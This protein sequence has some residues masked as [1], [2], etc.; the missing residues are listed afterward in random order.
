MFWPG[1]GEALSRTIEAEAAISD[2][3]AEAF[4]RWAPD[5]RAAVLPTLTG[6][7]VN[8]D[9]ALVA[10]ALPPDPDALA[11]TQS[12]WQQHAD[13]VIL[14]GLA[15]IWAAAVY[16]TVSDLGGGIIDT[17]E[18]VVDTAVL[19]I[20]L[21][22]LVGMRREEV[23]DAVGYVDA[24]PELA[25]A[26]DDY[27]ATKRDGVYAAPSLVHAKVEAALSNMTTTV[28]R[29]AVDAATPDAP[30]PT[31]TVEVIPET[32]PEVLRARAA[33]VLE[34]SSP[35]MRD[36]AR[37]EGYQAAEV[38]NN[39]VIAAAQMS[40]DADELQKVWVCVHP[41]TVVQSDEPINAARRWHDGF[42][43]TVRT[44]DDS[45]TFTVTPEHKVLTANRGW[46]AAQHLSE[47]DDLIKVDWSHT[48][49]CPHV[50]RE[51]ASIAEVVDA[52]FDAGAADE[53]GA[54]HGGVDFDV[55]DAA[56]GQVEVVRAD[57]E[58]RSHFDPGGPYASGEIEFMF[59]DL[60]RAALFRDR[61]LPQRG[62]GHATPRQRSAGS[63]IS[64][65]FD[66][67]GFGGSSQ[68]LGFGAAAGADTLLLAEDSRDGLGCASDLLAD[69]LG[70]HSG[71]VELVQVVSVDVSA[72]S[73]HVYDLQTLG[74]WFTANK[75][76]VHNCT[77]DGKTR[78]SH[79]AGDGQRVPLNGYFTIG[80]E[81]LFVPGDRS[82]SPAEWKN[83]RCRVG[84]LAADEEI[85]DEVDRHTERL[86]GRDSVAI[87]RNGRT[88]AEEIERRREAGNVRARDD[89]DGIGRVA[90]G[91]WTAPSEQEYSM[92]KTA[93]A[94][95]ASED[96]ETFL[97]FSDALFAVTGTP[98]SDG[99]MLAADIELTMRETPLPLQWCE[100]MEGG[101][102]GSVTVGVIESITYSNGEVRASGYMLNNENALKAIDL[103]SHGVNNPSV[104]LANVEWV[105]TD[106]KG[107]VV[108][109]E[110]YEEG[111]A[112][113]MTVTKAELTAT[114]I[115]AI[116][117]F[118]QTRIALN[119]EREVRAKA[120]V[121]SAAA[122]FTPRVYDAALFS[123]PKLTGPTPLS[124]DQETGR[125]FGHVACWSERHR[126]VGLGDITPPRS[127]SGYEHFHSSPP[128]H[129]SDGTKLPVGR[130]TV[131]IG[132]AP[133]SGV[134]N[135]EAQ[136]HYDNV[137][138]CFALVRAGEDAYG[139]WVSG[140]PA[141]WATPEK[142]EM[143]LAAPLS[144]DWRPYGGQ[145]DLVAVLA[146]NTPGFLC[147]GATDSY[148]KPLAMVAS[149]APARTVEMA[150]GATVTLADIKA[151]VA[152]AL[153]E[154]ART[155]ER[156]RRAEAALMRARTAVG[157][158]PPPPTPEERLAALLE[159]V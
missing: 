53:V 45:V 146:V 9:P 66:V 151:A 27:L 63:V 143:G 104:D 88:Q 94:T 98:T 126:S 144:G 159:R 67:G 108:T 105:A 115:V 21:A 48:V 79:W 19:G 41:D 13:E 85:P 76:V 42:M 26:R 38:L 127:P 90:S 28:E 72:F 96:E 71:P 61:A 100:E 20:V 1:R 68:D 128:V 136:A 44:S 95:L 135:D 50:K 47:G 54:V 149:L 15:V 64:G 33:E 55:E 59:P 52:F 109:E 142:I 39:A 155:A 81:Q 99:R 51:P 46:I 35:E 117:A 65:K 130:L 4:R 139:V 110:T 49:G 145:L 111:M 121:A 133:T 129:L 32:R 7:M 91:G 134:S 18:P 58:L 16:Q 140:V 14:A 158:P 74:C 73:G 132:H 102:F 152:E 29:P 93:T 30:E 23:L 92:G 82:A 25:A 69:R 77:I 34:A 141:P 80:G 12:A 6:H 113:Y 2:L 37:G 101:H 114:T 120:L 84:V 122:K 107:N 57:G 125:I 137:E 83:C 75:V 36:V 62:R 131:G 106:E 11:Q 138:A 60:A 40:D 112:V 124:I 103:V 10:A 153:A 147:R 17:V 154:S 24:H 70:G 5:A 87:N 78:P 89:E 123:D 43:V 8:G 3:Y 116:P 86:D 157:D 118:G 22:S 156:V 150:G 119:A 31:I 97:T 56:A 148:G